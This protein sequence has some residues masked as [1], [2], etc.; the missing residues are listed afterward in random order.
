MKSLKGALKGEADEEINI[1]Y[2]GQSN[3]VPRADRV[4]FINVK[5]EDD[6]M[7][8]NSAPQVRT[9]SGRLT[10]LVAPT[11]PSSSTSLSTSSLQWQEVVS[12]GMAWR[13]E[14]RRG[15]YMTSM[16]SDN[17]DRRWKD[18]GQCVAKTRYFP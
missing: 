13:L 3:N 18:P 9:C 5:S 6:N 1:V 2:E 15:N 8:E 14:Q 7:I 4:S 10:P 11:P 16:N 12:L 17:E